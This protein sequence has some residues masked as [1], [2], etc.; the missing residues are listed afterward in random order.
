MQVPPSTVMN[1]NISLLSPLSSNRPQSQPT[2]PRK[3]KRPTSS[4]SQHPLFL[5]PPPLLS[6]LT[7]GFNPTT[8]HLES[9]IR[10]DNTPTPQLRAVFVARGDTN[11]SQL[12]AHFPM[13]ASVLPNLRLV[14]LAKG[15]EAR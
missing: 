9:Q 13:M 12:Y 7:I 2:N 5:N 15:A 8:H 4:Q 6:F 1:A 11:S 3:R 10:H 14:S